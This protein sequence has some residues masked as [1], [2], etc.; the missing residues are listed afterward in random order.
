MLT[1]VSHWLY[2]K[3]SQWKASGLARTWTQ[4]Y[5]FF[6]A[7]LRIQRKAPNQNKFIQIQGKSKNISQEQNEIVNNILKALRGLQLRTFG[8]YP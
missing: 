3:V 4:V 6:L 5:N 1:F 2:I 7:V 8:L